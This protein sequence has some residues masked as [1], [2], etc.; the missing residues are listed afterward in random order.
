MDNRTPIS[1]ALAALLAAGPAAAQDLPLVSRQ[2]QFHAPIAV[3]GTAADGAATAQ[4]PDGDGFTEVPVVLTNVPR[5]PLPP[6][7]SILQRQIDPAT[8]LY[9][10]GGGEP[11]INPIVL[12]PSPA[13][14]PES[15]VPRLVVGQV[16]VPP[17]WDQVRNARGGLGPADPGPVRRG[18][19]PDDLRMTPP[20]TP[21]PIENGPGDSGPVQGGAAPSAPATP[22]PATAEPATAVAP[23]APIPLVSRRLGFRY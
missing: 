6:G 4:D 2:L 10:V 23:D 15:E 13:Q 21:A 22:Q 5:E 11:G 8:G 9:T 12:P 7:A 1:L 17:W 3:E 20:Q 14:L 16:Y 18:V 19:Q